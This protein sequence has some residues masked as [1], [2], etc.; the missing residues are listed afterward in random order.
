MR[1]INRLPDRDRWLAILLAAVIWSAGCDSATEP[2]TGKVTENPVQMTI[3]AA[4]PTEF[5]GTVGIDVSP[6]P[7]IRVT[8][9]DGEP[10]EGVKILFNIDGGTI[11][12]R[13]A[14][15]D[16]D[17]SATVGSWKLDTVA[18]TYYLTAAAG[19][20]KRLVFTATAVAGP[21]TRVTTV[22]GSDQLAEPG[23]TLDRPLLVRVSD[24]FDNP[25]AGALVEFMVI[26]G[27]GRMEN[28]LVVT[29]SVGMAKSG[30]WTFGPDVGIQQVRAVSGDIDVVFSCI[31]YGLP[32]DL[33]GRLAFVSGR[34]GNREIYSMNADGTGLT[35]LTTHSGSDEAPAWSPDGSRI[36]FESDGGANIYVMSADGS[37]SER[38]VSGWTPAWS[39]DGSTLAFGLLKDGAVRIA[40]VTDGVPGV[41]YL[42]DDPG[43]YAQPSWSPDGLR[44][45][46]VSDW[47]AYDFLSDI[48]MLDV[49]NGDVRALTQ[50]WDRLPEMHL[51]FHPVWSPDGSTIAVVH[52]RLATG[53]TEDLTHSNF[54]FEVALMPADGG[55][56]RDIAWAGDI[57]WWD[58]T[59]PGSLTWSPDGRGIAY[60]FIDCDL[61]HG[62]RCS[63]ATSVRYV[64]IDGIMRGT[65]IENADSPSW[66][67]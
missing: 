3:E 47:A 32:T 19:S 13:S 58:L 5:T 11:V 60:T 59:T 66:T 8:D 44:L 56:V 49:G 18:G 40:S 54:R 45:V 30:V 2:E 46:Y 14:V 28:S 36:A 6:V 57:S 33:T 4:T 48:Y 39:P 1:A 15:T 50:G 37:G 64:S 31:A 25:V 51:Y 43:Y 53:S 9:A 29:D 17:G 16:A 67:W 61:F 34:D 65:I 23:E 22:S 62:T 21:V 20:L 35:R 24:T 42:T 63:K 27:G 7:S 10:V 12:N 38:L 41:V 26:A 55:S 52:G